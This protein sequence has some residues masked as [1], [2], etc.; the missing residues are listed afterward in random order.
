MLLLPLF[1]YLLIVADFSL[2]RYSI[3]RGLAQEG[4][5]L[6]FAAMSSNGAALAA[7]LLI[8]LVIFWTYAMR[9][10]VTR[11]IYLLYWGIIFSRAAII[12]YHIRCLA[13]S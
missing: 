10:K 5:P 6:L 8:G 4:N 7:L 2:T 1:S 9:K 11:K 13:F 3:I 12:A